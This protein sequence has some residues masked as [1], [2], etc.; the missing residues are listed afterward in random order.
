MSALAERTGAVNLGQGFPDHDPPPDVLD[1]AVAALRRAL[2]LPMIFLT[3]K[4]SVI[5]GTS[6]HFYGL[7]RN[8]KLL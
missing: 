7:S 8:N 5:K 1:V 3:N 2:G 6:L 4:E